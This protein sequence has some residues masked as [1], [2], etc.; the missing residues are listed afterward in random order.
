MIIT[1]TY[2]VYFKPPNSILVLFISISLPRSVSLLFVHELFKSPNRRG[3]IIVKS[4]VCQ[5][6]FPFIHRCN[7][8]HRGKLFPKNSEPFFAFWKQNLL[9]QQICM[10]LFSSFMRI[11]KLQK[12]RSVTEQGLKFPFGH[13]PSLRVEQM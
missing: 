2:F 8:S 3:N 6:V 11:L 13:H 9:L 10:S 12:Y 4:I 7:I 1:P 5:N